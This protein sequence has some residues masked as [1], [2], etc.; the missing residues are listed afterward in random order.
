M[1]ARFDQGRAS[2]APTKYSNS[3]AQA[4]A[5]ATEGGV[6]PPLLPA[7]ED[8][9]VLQFSRLSGIFRRFVAARNFSEHGGNNPGFEGFVDRGRAVTGIAD[10]G[11]PIENVAEDFVLV[12]RSG[13]RVVGDFLLQIGNGAG[14]AG[15]VVELA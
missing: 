7:G 3:R 1:R 5:C 13:S 15:E 14:E 8:A 12:G 10:V 4:K 6:K 9:V 11:G 2:P